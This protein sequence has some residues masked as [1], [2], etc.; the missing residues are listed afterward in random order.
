MPD[1]SSRFDR[2]ACRADVVSKPLPAVAIAGVSGIVVGLLL[3]GRS[4][5]I[6]LRDAR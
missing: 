5:T 4:K 1:P 6:Y 3:R 2:T